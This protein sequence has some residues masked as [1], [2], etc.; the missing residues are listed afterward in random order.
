MPGAKGTRPRLSEARERGLRGGLPPAPDDLT[1]LRAVTGAATAVPRPGT[2]LPHAEMRRDWG[3][4]GGRTGPGS[5]SPREGHLSRSGANRALLSGMLDC[6]WA[7]S[8]ALM[9]L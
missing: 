9:G 8:T 7:R 1:R 6:G 2:P 5:A 3:Y 4:G